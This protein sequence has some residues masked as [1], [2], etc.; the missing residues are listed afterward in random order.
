[1]HWLKDVVIDI[2]ITLVILAYALWQPQWAWW[3]VVVYSSLMLLLKGAALSSPLLTGMSTK[4]GQEVPFWFY[5][6][7]YAVNV[8]ALLTLRWYVMAGVWAA[9]WIMS[10]AADSQSRTKREAKAVTRKERVKPAH[11]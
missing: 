8:F 6:I 5:H 1:M 3:I 4:K 9:I 11:R 10:I 7:L 2:A